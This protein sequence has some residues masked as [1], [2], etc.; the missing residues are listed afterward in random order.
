M[1]ETVPTISSK[2]ELLALCKEVDR[3]LVFIPAWK[4]SVWVRGVTEDERHRLGLIGQKEPDAN[5]MAKWAAL[6]L[7][8]EDGER[9]L[10]DK[11]VGEIAKSA[12]SAVQLIVATSR[13][14]SALTPESRAELGKASAATS[15]AALSSV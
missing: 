2:D 11:E 7:V 4:T 5:I 14:L 10:S 1:T 15:D 3:E 12:A 8:K 9:W 13:K 6:V